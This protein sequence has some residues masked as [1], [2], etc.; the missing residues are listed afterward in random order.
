MERRIELEG[1]VNFR[2]LGGYPTR[3]GRTI[4]WRALFRSDAL[5][6]LTPRDVSLLREQLRMSDIV[7]LRSSFELDAEGRGLLEQEPI[8]FHHAPLFDGDT[9]AAERAAAEKLVTLADR[10]VGMLDFAREPI[11]RVIEILAHSQ[12]GAV[13]HCAA[14]KDRTGV[15]SAVVLGVLDVPD[16]L[17]VADYALSAE[18]IEA[19][20][21]RVMS[22]KGYRDTLEDLPADTLHAKPETMEAVLAHVAERYGSMSDYLL[23]AGVKPETL[24]R[25]RARGL[26]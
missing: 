23:E 16:E 14:G 1:C 26:D 21:D 8:G 7:D 13:Y 2:D 5:H 17:I 25:L 20:I 19:I 9:R 11:A 24:E 18:N 4:R 6:A 3:S 22:M 10:Y 15:I 12:G